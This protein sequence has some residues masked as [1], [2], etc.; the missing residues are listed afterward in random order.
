MSRGK[1]IAL[2]SAVKLMVERV[3]RNGAIERPRM[4]GKVQGLVH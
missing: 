4:D 3:R 1:G 2:S